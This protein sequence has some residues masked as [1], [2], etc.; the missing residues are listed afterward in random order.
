MHASRIR[1]VAMAAGVRA[2][3]VREF[4]ACG[5]ENKARRARYMRR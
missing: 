1:V 3:A 2:L 4:N 5:E